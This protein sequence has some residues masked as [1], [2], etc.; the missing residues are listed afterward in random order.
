MSG[1]SCISVQRA[2]VHSSIY[3]EVKKKLVEKAAKVS[4]N[5]SVNFQI[6]LTLNV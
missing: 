6:A 4:L 5:K 1:Q 3:D 2:Y